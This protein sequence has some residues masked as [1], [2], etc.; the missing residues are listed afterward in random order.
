MSDTAPETSH[1]NYVLSIVGALGSILLFLFIVLIAYVYMFQPPPVDEQRTQE[2]FAFR[3]DVEAKQTA[4][5]TEY[6][7]VDQKEGVV[8]IPVQVA[9]PIA[10]KQIQNNPDGIFPPAEEATEVV[11]T[12]VPPD[13]GDDS[14]ANE[15][16][17]PEEKTEAPVEG[18]AQTEADSTP[19]SE[20]AA[21]ESPAAGTSN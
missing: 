21:A 18:E 17:K 15:D 2:R 8:R 12:Y 19:E 7:W 14:D 3:R 16:D 9:V 1:S 10:V 6:A 20:S 4:L 11:D 5:T 13:Y